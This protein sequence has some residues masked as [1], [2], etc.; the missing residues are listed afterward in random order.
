MHGPEEM[1]VLTQADPHVED[2][3]LRMVQLLAEEAPDEQFEQLS[4]AVVAQPDP[5][6]RELLA[7]A[8]AR[9]GHVREV[10]AHHKRREQETQAL[11][12]TA[13]DLTSLRDVDEALTAIVQR[14]RQLLGPDATYLALVDEN[15]GDAYMRVTAGTV[16]A[17]IQAVRLA[18]GW[19]VGG[20]IIQ[21]GQ[22]FAT[23]NYHED[24]RISHDP[25]VDAAVR[26][27]GLVS[28]AGVPMKLRDE[29][30]GALFVAYRHERT[31]AASDVALLSSLADHASVVINN[32]RLF[33][34][35]QRGA[36]DLREANAR[37]RAHGRTLE[38]ASAA[39]EQLM[40]LALRRADL[41]ELA[42]RVC[43]I[44]PGELLLVGVDGQVLAS[45]P[46]GTT[47]EGG[48]GLETA[49]RRL[50][51]EATQGAGRA[52]AA[53]QALDDAGAPV[54]VAPVQAGDETFAHLLLRARQELD[55]AD[56]RTLERAAQ[57]AALLL[58]MERQVSLLEEQLRGEL[59]DDLLAPQPPDWA[60]FQRRAKRA[61]VVDLDLPH[62]VLVLSSDQ[63][64]RRQLLR[65][66]SDYAA[67]REGLA[68]EHSTGVVLLL[69]DRDP[70]EA[71]QTVSADL[72]RAVRA[73]VTVGAAGP[74]AGA[75]LVRELYREADRCRRLLVSLGRSGQGASIAD[76]GTLGLV[77]EGTTQQQVR[78][79][80]AATIGPLLAYDEDN[81]ALLLE[82]LRAYFGSGRNPPA[83]ARAL[84]VH[85][86][87]VYQRLDRVDQVLG[88]RRWREP[89]GDLEM[90][91]ALQF[92]RILRE[93][94]LEELLAR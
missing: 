74:G 85:P 48:L 30:I 15:T 6:R 78:R 80:L 17:P 46:A 14:V 38:R 10:L 29:L 84:Q 25:V 58:L 4:A 53:V 32:A 81:N 33:E 52:G 93:I 13:R 72:S 51:D 87:T 94:P 60:V 76:L 77:L 64:P 12:E 2:L 41:S 68:S 67:L 73:P 23:S 1:Q 18:P 21:T 92:H 35:L 69:P 36:A 86:N 71:A 91:L 11:Y 43:A 65:A 42:E 63:V 31:F 59:M 56:V 49:A 50:V 26:A 45:D 57:T 82:T 54:W 44:L 7:M 39:H 9:S 40:P 28:M 16:T 5:V 61:G 27:D 3:L 66:A 55:Q 79:L 22:P 83:A 89:Q 88:H 90:Q 62:T 47:S 34:G 20:L 24:T 75:P 8:M 70:G 19:G 37:L